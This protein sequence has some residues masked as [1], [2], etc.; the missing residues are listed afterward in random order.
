M[1]DSM[2]IKTSLLFFLTFCCIVTPISCITDHYCSIENEKNREKIRTNYKQYT[3]KF[4]KTL[5]TAYLG[6]NFTGSYKKRV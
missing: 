3:L 5:R 6:S 1:T 4:M 2:S